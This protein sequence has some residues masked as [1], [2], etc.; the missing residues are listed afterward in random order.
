MTKDPNVAIAIAFSRY[1]PPEVLEPLDVGDEHPAAGQVRVQVRAAG[2]QP[3]DCASRRGALAQWMPVTFPCRLGNELAGVIDEVA[4]DVASWSVGD[5]VLGFEQMAC[6]A[7]TVIV[8]AD[9]LVAKP[10]AMPWEEA[11]VLPASGQTAHSALEQLGVEQGDTVLVHAAAGGV[12]SF[13]VQIAR[14]TGA[15]VIG[16]ARASNHE[17]L[18]GLGAIPVSYGSGL[19]ARV[20]TLAPDGVTA[21]LDC[22]GGNALDVSTHLV[23]DRSRI[24]TIADRA[25]AA[26]LDIRSL[27]T[28]R[29]A[30]RLTELV[31]LYQ[32]KALAAPIWTSFPLHNAAEAHRQVENGHVRG[33][34]VLTAG[35]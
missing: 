10:P 17:Y 19:E 31:R 14:A 32:T 27:G 20:H 13:A 5:E 35:G 29:S 2:V 34:V 1:G 16:T 7:E 22:I 33:K 18:A 28:Q 25:G 9:Q 23:A 12:G 11:G 26:R 3:F 15:T 30:A 24:G 6:Y 21:V 4:D 8:G